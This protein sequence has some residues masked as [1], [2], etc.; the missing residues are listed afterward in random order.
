MA[1]NGAVLTGSNLRQLRERKQLTRAQISRKARIPYRT[2]MNFEQGRKKELTEAESNRIH[3]ALNDEPETRAWPSRRTTR[4]A[5]PAADGATEVQQTA[6]IELLGG[7][8]LDPAEG[9]LVPEADAKVRVLA[10]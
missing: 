7:W 2:L 1:T 9:T 6:K 4:A 10:R 3:A 8:L 5:T